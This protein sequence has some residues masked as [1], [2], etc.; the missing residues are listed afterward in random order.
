MSITADSF[1][2]K[3]VES[4][5]ERMEQLFDRGFYP[6]LEIY[7]KYSKHNPRLSGEIAHPKVFYWYLIRELYR[8]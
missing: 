6:H 3:D 8:L 4:L 5:C 2:K 1:T 7:R